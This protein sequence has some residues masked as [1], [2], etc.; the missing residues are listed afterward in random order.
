MFELILVIALIIAIYRIL[1]YKIAILAVKR[2]LREKGMEMSTEE[3][4]KNI[5]KVIEE[6]WEGRK[7]KRKMFNENKREI[8]I[9]LGIL[10][11]ATRAGK[12]IKVLRLSEDENFV[13]IV[14][15]N[16]YKKDVCVEADSGI[17]LIKDVMNAL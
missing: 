7:D 3:M 14:W 10:L 13:K 9:R 11:K 8:V 2:W 15:K 12:D 4:R 5:T 1:A 17:A 16:G 6:P